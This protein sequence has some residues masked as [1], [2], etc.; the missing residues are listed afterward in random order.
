VRVEIPDYTPYISASASISV[1]TNEKLST[2]EAKALANR[3]KK[4][5]FGFTE[6]SKGKKQ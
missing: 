1:L 4:Q 3:K 5:P 6:W 2:N